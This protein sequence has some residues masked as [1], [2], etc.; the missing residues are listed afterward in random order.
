MVDGGWF[1][2][3]RSINHPPSTINPDR[4][5]ERAAVRRP[6]PGRPAGLPGH[7]GERELRGPGQAAW[8]ERLEADHANLSAASA[9]SLGEENAET[10]LRFCAALWRFWATRGYLSE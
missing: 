3:V 6:C 7:P 1:Q 2:T 4:V 10:A 5:P 9:W 8:L